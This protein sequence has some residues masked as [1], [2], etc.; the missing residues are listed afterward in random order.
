MLVKKLVG[1][2]YRGEGFGLDVLNSGPPVSNGLFGRV[3]S[4]GTA[5]EPRTK[6]GGDVVIAFITIDTDIGRQACVP[7]RTG[8]P[9]DTGQAGRP[10]QRR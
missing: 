8:V 1:L 6:K 7:S 10:G 5:W 9:E 3:K 4:R 2:V